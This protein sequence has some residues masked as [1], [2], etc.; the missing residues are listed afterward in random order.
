[1]K[2]LYIVK[3]REYAKRRKEK[4]IWIYDKNI[5]ISSISYVENL[6]EMANGKTDVISEL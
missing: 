4:N 1:M 2:K 6:S 3:W 5:Y